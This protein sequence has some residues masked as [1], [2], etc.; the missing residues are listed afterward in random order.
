MAFGKKRRRRKKVGGLVGAQSRR[1]K[2]EKLLVDQQKQLKRF[3][4]R[5]PELGNALED[6]RSKAAEGYQIPKSDYEVGDHLLDIFELALQAG[7]QRKAILAEL[8]AIFAQKS[9]SNKYLALLKAASFPGY[10]EKLLSKNA[11]RLR[12]AIRDGVDPDDFEDYR[13]NFGNPKKGKGA[14]R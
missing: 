5:H 11:Q 7:E 13:K 3:K 12:G 6:I 9:G 4:A 2:K 14:K 1:D 10:N 8:D